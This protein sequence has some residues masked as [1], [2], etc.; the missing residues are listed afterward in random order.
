MVFL[1]VVLQYDD[2]DW[3]MV[4]DDPAATVAELRRWLERAGGW[5]PYLFW[6]DYR[7]QTVS[8]LAYR[9]AEQPAAV[10]QA[11]FRRVAPALPLGRI[12]DVQVSEADDDDL[13]Q[14]ASLRALAAFPPSGRPCQRCGAPPGSHFPGCP[15]GR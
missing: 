10:V 12:F 7:E 2:L 13:L 4:G 3:A 1:I 9:Q 8:A 11:V 6:P 15:W 5:Q 14:E